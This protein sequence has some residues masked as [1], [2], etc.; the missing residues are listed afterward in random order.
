[1]ARMKR[2]YVRSGQLKELVEAETRSE[3]MRKALRRSPGP[4]GLLILAYEIKP[5]ETEDDWERGIINSDI[6]GVTEFIC[7]ELGISVS[8]RGGVK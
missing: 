7:K 5:G 3:A 4:Y 6:A 2:W 1:M 8:M